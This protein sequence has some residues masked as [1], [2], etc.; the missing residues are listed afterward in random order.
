MAV[1][2]RIARQKVVPAYHGRIA[3]NVAAAE[4]ALLQHRD[5]G[6]AVVFGEVVCRAQPMAAAADDDRV[7][8]SL[9][10]RIAPM[11]R[12]TA[13]AGQPFAQHSQS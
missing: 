1:E 3:P 2:F 5:I 9:R 13:I 7:I 6:H 10:L 8:L 4:I 11:R 12:P